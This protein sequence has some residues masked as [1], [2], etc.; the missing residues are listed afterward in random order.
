MRKETCFN[1]EYLGIPIYRMYMKCLICYREISMK[2]D[3]KNHDY[4]LEHGAVRLYESWKDTRASENLLK[5]MRKNQEDGNNIK[6]LEHKTYDS[7]KEMDRIEA[8]DQ[9]R[10][11]SKKNAKLE[12]QDLL[13]II[14]KKEKIEVESQC[15]EYLEKVKQIS[16]KNQK[17]QR[18]Q[19]TE[20]V[21][22]YFKQKNLQK[23]LSKPK[24]AKFLKPQLRFKKIRKTKTVN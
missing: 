2:T 9:M 22:E 4:T 24:R 20:K 15:Q 7:K 12:T 3:P 6:F 21:R 1:E 18:N 10:N 14:N 5:K 13:E 8:I 16:L 23:I 11:I 19:T 17:Y